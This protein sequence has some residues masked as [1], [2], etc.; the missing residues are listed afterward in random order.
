MKKIT[1][2]ILILIIICITTGCGV[3]KTKQIAIENKG[4]ELTKT[5]LDNKGITDYEIISSSAHINKS[6]EIWP[7]I[8]L[9]STLSGTSIVTIK[10]K[11]VQ[12]DIL[13]YC[14]E[15]NDEKALDMMTRYNERSEYRIDTKY[16]NTYDDILVCTNNKEA[17]NFTITKKKIYD[18]YN[19]V[20]DTYKIKS[21]EKRKYY[22]VYIPTNRLNG[23]YNNLLFLVTQIR[24]DK[25]YTDE[26]PLRLTNDYKYYT[27]NFFTSSYEGL[28]S[29]TE[30]N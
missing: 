20:I 6:I 21:Q 9:D 4:I 19:R 11:G 13:A 1:K 10:Y 28:F 16:C 7:D 5:W 23:K 29:I 22:K 30:S 18:S 15:R 3:S 14:D 12:K 25:D 26:Y 8:Y 17:P 27:G 24:K 2:L